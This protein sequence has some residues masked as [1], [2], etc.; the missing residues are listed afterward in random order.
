MEGRKTQD[1]AW[2]LTNA[3]YAAVNVSVHNKSQVTTANPRHL[4]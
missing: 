3:A 4:V 2:Q 1:Q